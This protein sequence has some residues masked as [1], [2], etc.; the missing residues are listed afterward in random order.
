MS[1]RRG[2][3]IQTFTGVQF[4]PLDPRADEIRIEDIAHALAQQCRFGGHC[5]SFYSVAEHSV[6]VSRVVP[7]QDALWGL[8]HDGS[9]AYCVDVPRPLK[10]HLS[11]Y[12]VIE[13]RLMLAIC[14]RFRLPVTMPAS[15]KRA[16]QVL[17]NTEKR[18]LTGPAPAPWTVAQGMPTEPLQERIEPW[19]PFEAKAR[20]LA[21]FYELEAERSWP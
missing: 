10:R 8:L 19:S 18:D 14:E 2:D 13:N 6:R 16:D 3:W 1:E 17:L 15:V 9:E 4:W 7:P 20:F 12:G 11:E 5:R 21:R